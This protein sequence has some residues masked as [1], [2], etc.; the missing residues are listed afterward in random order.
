MKKVDFIEAVNSGKRFRVFGKNKSPWLSV[1]KNGNIKGGT[2]SKK[3]F[4]EKFELEE[5]SISVTESDFD[6]AWKKI[7][8]STAYRDT[9]K[10][11][12]GF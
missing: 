9:L 6:K 4:N 7:S 5:K 11:K 1:G 8:V 3:M 10:K 12:L 2:A